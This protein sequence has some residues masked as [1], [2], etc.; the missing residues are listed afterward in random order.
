MFSPRFHRFLPDERL[1]DEGGGALLKLQLFVMQG[2]GVGSTLCRPLAQQDD[3]VVV[4]EW[5]RTL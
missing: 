3:A 4:P 2:L 5:Q 1:Q